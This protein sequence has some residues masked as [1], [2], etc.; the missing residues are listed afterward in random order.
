MKYGTTSVSSGINFP[1][2][3]RTLSVIGTVIQEALEVLGPE[4]GIG[5]ATPMDS[6]LDLDLVAVHAN[7]G[8]S[9]INDSTTGIP[10]GT[11]VAV[12]IIFTASVADRNAP[13]LAHLF[14]PCHF[15]IL[16]FANCVVR[17][18]TPKYELFRLV[19]NGSRRSS[20]SSVSQG[21]IGKTEEVDRRTIFDSRSSLEERSLLG[22]IISSSAYA[23]LSSS[24]LLIT[25]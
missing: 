4:A 17:R 8:K 9:L 2:T 24:S 7:A 5:I 15:A 23:A 11:N 10:N 14:S 3:T 1:F 18:L 13:S 21:D 19:R 22:S 6:D 25:I 16:S 12:F 20:S